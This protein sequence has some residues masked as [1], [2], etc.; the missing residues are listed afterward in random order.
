M[1]NPSAV[2]AAFAPEEDL[3]LT[4]EAILVLESLRCALMVG[5]EAGFRD[6]LMVYVAMTNLELLKKARRAGKVEEFLE[7][8]GKGEKP[9][10]FIAKKDAILAAIKS[11]CTPACVA[12]EAENED[13]FQAVK[14]S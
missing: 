11:A 7:E 8:V 9:S 6:L 13:G 14:K 3:V 5:G 2:L 12:E 1:S 4:I 10:E